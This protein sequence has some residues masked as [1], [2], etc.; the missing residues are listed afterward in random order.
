MTSDG[1]FVT[2]EVQGKGAVLTLDSPAN[3]NALSRPLVADMVEILESFRHSDEVRA[4]V[5]TA[6]G[7]TF[8]SGADLSDP[9]VGTGPGSYSHLLAL[10]WEYP[11]PVIAAVNGHV[12]AGGL[13][14]LAVS[15]ISFAVPASTFAFTEVRI[16]VAPAMISVVCLRKMTPA[17]GARYLLTGEKF[18]AAEAVGCG[19]VGSLTD[20]L[21]GSVATL[22]ADFALCEPQALAATR[23][24]LHRIPD[25]PVEQGFAEAAVLA[26]KLFG[27]E[28]AAEGIAAFKEKRPPRWAL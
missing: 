18:G 15:D 11:K 17:S 4:V 21:P 19:L 25:L 24:L 14:L 20:D 3:R 8:C 9:P 1:S 27:S 10:L 22:L 12:R 16:G 5:L 2:V 6:T 23:G 26:E 28:A 7:T 13:G